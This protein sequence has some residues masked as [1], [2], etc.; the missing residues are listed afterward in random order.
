[1]AHERLGAV[2]TM[3]TDAS[4]APE[5]KRATVL[6]VEDDAVVRAT[7]TEALREAGYRVLE[8]EDAK[9]ARAFFQSKE[10]VAVLV[11]DVSLPGVSGIALARWAAESRPRVKII[12]ISGYPDKAGDAAKVGYF[13]QKPFRAERLVSLVNALLEDGPSAPSR[14]GH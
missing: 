6:L 4:V 11:S 10:P 5:R 1:M 3:T 8:A 14:R 13:L 7:L 2:S 12:M 9:Q